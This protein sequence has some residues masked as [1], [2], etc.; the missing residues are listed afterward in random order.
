M[1]AP[2]TIAPNTAPLASLV[3][4]NSIKEIYPVKDSHSYINPYNQSEHAWTTGQHDASNE[5]AWSKE[6][7]IT[8]AGYTDAVN[9]TGPSR[10][11]PNV[12]TNATLVQKAKEIYPVKDSHSYITPYYQRDHAWTAG[13]HDVSDEVKWSKETNITAADHI[14]WVVNEPGTRLNTAAPA[15]TSSLSQQDVKQKYRIETHSIILP[16][17]VR[18]SAW[19]FDHH[20]NTNFTAYK[21]DAPEGYNDQDYTDPIVIPEGNGTV[22]LPNCTDTE[23]ANYAAD[24]AAAN[25]SGL[26]APVATC[27]T[28]AARAAAAAAAAAAR[29]NVTNATNATNGT[30]AT[31]A[32]NACNATNATNQTNA[33][34]TPAATVALKVNATPAVAVKIG[35][36]KTEVPKV[37]APVAH[38]PVESKKPSASNQTQAKPVV[39]K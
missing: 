6:T 16:Y 29:C 13:Q 3:Q 18:D 19:N 31:N 4:R 5:V 26:P 12:S 38:K 10:L 22:V 24:V 35:S 33:T 32:S 27:T 11:V 23:E 28:A 20:D 36:K 7:N 14:D 39:T 1:T 8:A 15:N 37:T 25:H 9:N 30:N 17:V 2:E 34:A 21:E